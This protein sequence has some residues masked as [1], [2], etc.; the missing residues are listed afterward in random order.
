MKNEN[1]EIQ[2]WQLQSL[3]QK[4]YDIYFQRGFNQFG[5]YRDKNPYRSCSFILDPLF[6]KYNFLRI[7]VFIFQGNFYFR[8]H[9]SDLIGNTLF[10]SQQ[11]GLVG[12]L[13]FTPLPGVLISN[14]RDGSAWLT[15][16]L[17]TKHP[18]ATIIPTA[19]FLSLF[20][21]PPS[22]TPNFYLPRRTRNF[23]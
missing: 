14:I 23:K 1:L 7:L 4:Q 9:R 16:R 21:R 6:F 15:F 5:D 20:S 2:I 8:F 3:E 17:I 22:Q 12:Y 11:S 18:T 19:Y 10:F 13:F